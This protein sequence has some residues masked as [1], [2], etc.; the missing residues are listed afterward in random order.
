NQFGGVT[1]CQKV[2]ADFFKRA[3]E[4]LRFV[5]SRDDDAQ[6]EGWH[7]EQRIKVKPQRV[8]AE[9]SSKRAKGR[10]QRAEGSSPSR[11]FS[12]VTYHSSLFTG[13]LS[14][15]FGP[16]VFSDQRDEAAEIEQSSVGLPAVLEN[17][18]KK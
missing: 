17:L 1:L 12:R 14:L 16:A 10:K 5:V 4:A 11:C 7:V 2:G 8:K 15:F 13:H 3:T 9:G 18:L 6:S